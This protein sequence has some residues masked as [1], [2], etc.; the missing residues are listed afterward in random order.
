MLHELEGKL[1]RYA[2][3]GFGKVRVQQHNQLLFVVGHAGVQGH[4][5]RRVGTGAAGMEAV[6]LL[7]T[8]RVLPRRHGTP[9]GRAPSPIEHRSHRD[10]P[11]VEGRGRPWFLQHCDSDLRRLQ[12]PDA[13]GFSVLQQ[14]KRQFQQASRELRELSR[15]PP[16]EPT[17]SCHIHG[18]DTKLEITHGELGQLTSMVPLLLRAHPP[19][20]PFAV[21]SD[22][23][24]PLPPSCQRFRLDAMPFYFDA[25]I[26]GGL[27]HPQETASRRWQRSVIGQEVN[28]RKLRPQ[29]SRAKNRVAKPAPNKGQ[30]GWAGQ[31]QKG[32]TERPTRLITYGGASNPPTVPCTSASLDKIGVTLQKRP[33]KNS[34]GSKALR[35]PV[36]PYRGIGITNKGS[37]AQASVNSQV[38]PK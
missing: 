35:E 26:K 38:T 15:G 33:A 29:A 20:E 18:M 5:S 17:G 27:E 11:Q 10:G 14:G 8:P 36:H 2:I 9:P 21:V 34:V 22:A 32:G 3:K 30:E 16:V 4:G 28:G 12:R 19:K 23:V 6:L 24:H 31:R 7:V 13:S 25:V 1:P 37:P